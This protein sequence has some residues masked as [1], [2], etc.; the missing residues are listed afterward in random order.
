MTLI[1]KELDI[2]VLGFGDAGIH[3]ETIDYPLENRYSK[4]V[5]FT[6]QEPL[7]KGA[8]G[9]TTLNRSS[10]D[11]LFTWFNVARGKEKSWLLRVPGYNRLSHTIESA[12]GGQT[13]QGVLLPVVGSGTQYQINLHTNGLE[14]ESF[15]P[16]RFP[17]Q[18]SVKVYSDNVQLTE[19][20][21]IDSLGVVIFSGPPLGGLTVDCIY[22]T[23]V[24]FDTDTFGGIYI[25]DDQYLE[26][27]TGLN[28]SSSLVPCQSWYTAESL[29][30]IEVLPPF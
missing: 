19:G 12:G 6:E 5:Q 30:F 7:I 21:V 10:F 26:D 18:S 23:P 25:K 13:T 27:E 4:R 2:S 20:F 1:N 15:K 8:I 14:V 22:L 9:V 11:Y 29:P 17:I 28:Q 24:R 3:H 16:I